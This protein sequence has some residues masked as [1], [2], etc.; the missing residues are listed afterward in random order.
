VTDFT[1][2]SSGSGG[3]LVTSEFN[4]K[5]NKLD[6]GTLADGRTM[7]GAADIPG[8]NRVMLD[9]KYLRT[10]RNDNTPME[11]GVGLNIGLSTTLFDLPYCSMKNGIRINHKITWAAINL[12]P[13]LF[14]GN[15]NA[16]LMPTEARIAWSPDDP[17]AGVVPTHFS[18]LQYRA[19]TSRLYYVVN[20]VDKFSID[21]SGNVRAAGT[22]TGSVTP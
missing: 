2:L 21:A 17:D 13:V 3:S 1:T 8:A 18:Y 11:C 22:I 15:A 12:H 9:L 7:N 19:A 6:D 14:Q 20:G 4:L 10:D 16:I 5:A